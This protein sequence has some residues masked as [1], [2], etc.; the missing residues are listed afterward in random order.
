MQ[1][2][3]NYKKISK[4]IDG[5]FDIDAARI[6][7]YL[8]SIQK[9]ENISGNIFEIGVHHGKSSLLLGMFIDPDNNKL[10]VNDIFDQQE[11]NIS[12]SGFGSEQIFKKNFKK[13]FK[14]ENGLEIIVKPSNKLTLNDTTNECIFF[15][16]D[17]GHS[18]EETY[19]DLV[20]AKNAISKEGMIAIDD[21]F[22][23]GFPGVS[24]G[25]CRFLIENE[26]IVPWIYCFNKMILIRKDMLTKYDEIL[27]RNNFDQFCYKNNFFIDKVTFFANDVMIF[28]KRTTSRALLLLIRDKLSKYSIFKKMFPLILK[29]F[30]SIRKTKV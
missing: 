8:N 26:D 13:F 18:S 20:T 19:I 27:K 3:N 24:E 15:S 28:K 4:K 9:K 16:I 14:T 21:Y 23:S 10:I 7:Y 2:F 12:K 6:F 17:G 22:N 11:H 25:V 1:N 29:V 5:W 30:P